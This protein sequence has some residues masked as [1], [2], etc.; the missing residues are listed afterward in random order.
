M[1]YNRYMGLELQRL[2]QGLEG[3]VWLVSVTF[4]LLVCLILA[5]VPFLC[6]LLVYCFYEII[7]GRPVRTV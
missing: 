5:V 6:P 1:S 2:F 7:T 3:G 4:L